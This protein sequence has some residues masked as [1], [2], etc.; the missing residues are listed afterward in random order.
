[1]DEDIALIQYSRNSIFKGYN[2][3]AEKTDL[4]KMARNQELRRA[5]AFYK[6]S[7]LDFPSFLLL[8]AAMFHKRR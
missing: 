1:M 6:T 2:V 4:Y 5:W 8:Y 3:M 7:G